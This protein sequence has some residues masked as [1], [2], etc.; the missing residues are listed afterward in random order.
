MKT[1]P[2]PGIRKREAAPRQAIRERAPEA[3][4]VRA[5]R[6]QARETAPEPGSRVMADMAADAAARAADTEEGVTDIICGL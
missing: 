2:K 1:A 6:E 5:I 3:V 4:M